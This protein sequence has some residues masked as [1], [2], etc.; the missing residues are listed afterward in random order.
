[1]GEEIDF[2]WCVPTASDGPYEPLYHAKVGDTIHFEWTGYHDVHIYPSEA[3]SAVE[4]QFLG[5]QSGTS[6]NF[7]EDDIGELIFS[8]SVGSHCQMGQIAKFEVHASNSDVSY[9]TPNPCDD[10]DHDEHDHHHDHDHDHDMSA[11]SAL[12]IFTA[13]TLIVALGAFV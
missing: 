7:T 3:C 9:D 11:A 4:A 5:A 12:K 6:Y 13:F 2:A 1:M 10:H 8:C